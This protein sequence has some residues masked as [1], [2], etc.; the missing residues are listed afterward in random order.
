MM[1]LEPRHLIL[2]PV[3]ALSAWL[4]LLPPAG[5]PE[6]AAPAGALV[7]LCIGLWATGAVAEHL[8]AMVLFFLAM[9]FAIAP[10]A[11]VFSGFAS[12]AF[13]LVFGGLIIGAA[14]DVTG[15][16]KRLARAITARISGGYGAVIGG[17]VTVSVVLIFL[18]PSTL[19]RIVLLM[20]IILA[21]ADRLGYAGGSR[22]RNGMVLAMI[23]TS[24]LCSVGVLP[25]NVPNNVL[26]GAAETSHGVVIRYFDYLLLHFP[27]LG[28][29]KAVVIAL[30]LTWSFAE[31]PSPRKDD[32]AEDGAGTWAGMNF[33]ERKMALYLAIAL[34][35]WATDAVHGISPAWISLGVGILCLLPFTGLVSADLYRQKISLNP[36]IYI[37]GIL[38]V[39]AL[40]AESG[41]GTWLGGRL[42]AAEGLEPGNPVEAFAVITGLGTLLGMIS[43]MPAVPAVLV[44]LGETLSEASGFPLFHVMN[45]IVVGFSTVILPYQVPPFVIGMQLGNVP[46]ADGARACLAL[47]A[48]SVLVILP[49]NYIWWWAL[50]MFG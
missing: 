10:P 8:V 32:A 16:G 25:A 47:A 39:G 20:P 50:G 17:I 31:P 24:Y 13:W 34:V 38:A 19:S 23:L 44:P 41:L 45:L 36:L 6:G 46:L 30:F 43:T 49:L 3:L 27:V 1:K 37:A 26:V 48:L 7:V 4:A 2:L 22:G 9:V 5:M 12:G 21:L 35:L 11:I 33:G 40:V 15:L 18:M 29:V 14:V 42:I 28:G